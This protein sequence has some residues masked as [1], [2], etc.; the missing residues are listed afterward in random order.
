MKF[1]WPIKFSK[2][3]KRSSA[4]EGASTGRR[5]SGWI[6]QSGDSNAMIKRDLPWL[7]E[8]SRFL[9]RNNSL[10]HKANEVITNN[11]VGKGIKTEIGNASDQVKQIWKDWAETTNCDFDGRHDLDGLQRLAM[12]AVVESGE[13]LIRKRYV[14]DPLFPIKY[15]VLESEFL[16]TDAEGMQPNGNHVIQGIEFSPDGQRIAYHIYQQHPGSVGLHTSTRIFRIP[17]SEIFHLYRQERP[18]QARGVPWSSPCMIRLKDLDDFKDA[19]VM[20]QKIANLFVAFVSDISADVECDDNSDLGEKMVPAM[21]EHLPPGKTIDFADP[22][23]AENFDEFT[24]VN[25]RE[26]ASAF[27]ITYESLTGDYSNTNFSSGRMGW[28]QESRNF[29]AW[30]SGIMINGFLKPAEQDFLLLLTLRG[31]VFSDLIFEHIAP[32]RELID[33]QKEID[34][35]VTAIRAGLESRPSAIKSLGRDP[36]AITRS[37]QEDNEELDEKGLILD[38]DPRNTNNSGNLQTTGVS[39]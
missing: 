2:N 9:R 10:A 14:D 37:I 28:I 1:Q 5:T 4:Y 16:A 31:A 25:H 29:D 6:T 15:Q 18:G 3:K 27:G 17:A 24:K 12:D 36:E 13:V 34:A 21:I 19:T 33:P 7:R 11:V 35:M 26:I 23:K 8:R 30:R 39:T 32:K 38:T 22:P 20:R